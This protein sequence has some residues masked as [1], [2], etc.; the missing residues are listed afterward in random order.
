M[1][2]GAIALAVS[3]L[4]D[5]GGCRRSACAAGPR[6]HLSPLRAVLALLAIIAAVGLIG[7]MTSADA[8]VAHVFSTSFAVT[9]TPASIAVDQST[10]NVYVLNSAGNIQ[11]FSAAGA[12]V[13]FSSLGTNVLSTGCG[14]NCRQVAVDNSGGINQG[15]I[16]VSSSEAQLRVFLPSGRPGSSIANASRTS[17]V[18]PFCGVATD[19]SGVVYVVHSGSENGEVSYGNYVDT[20]K[21]GQIRPDPSPPQTWLVA[22][23]MGR[24]GNPQPCRVAV[25]ANFHMYVVP[26]SASSQTVTGQLLRFAINPFGVSEPAGIPIDTGSSYQAVNESN[27]DL[28]SDH[29]TSIRRFNAA[30]VLRE[31]FGTGQLEE[32]YGVAVN[33]TNGTVYATSKKAPS[34]V[35]IFNA[36]IT[37]DATTGLA[38]GGQ[39]T[40][41]IAGLVETADAG[42]VTGCQFEYGTSTAYG[43]TAACTPGAPFTE[44]THVT[45]NLTGLSKETT[46]HYRI[47][48]TNANGTTLGIDQ[49]FT[50]HNV[51]SVGTEPPTEVSQMSA[52]LRGGFVG[53]GEPM[54]YYFEWGSTVSYGNQ[55]AVP[56]GE[57][58]G[59][60]SGPTSV[61][62]AITGLSVRLP[63]STPYHY[64]L[65]AIN[66]S[67]TTYSPDRTFFAAPP[68]PPQIDGTSSSEVAPTSATVSATINPGNGPTVYYLEYGPDASYGSSTLAGSSI[69]SDNLEHAVSSIL[70]GLTPGTTYHYRVVASN[71]GGT[72][73]GADQSFNTPNAPI[74]SGSSASGIGQTAATLEAQVLPGFSSAT[75]HFEY[76][77]TS[78]YGSTTAESG[79][80]G[81]DNAAHL[82]QAS[83]GGLKPG[84]AY[85][86]R[87]VVTNQIGS[88]S[89]PDG[90]FTTS[91]VPAAKEAPREQPKPV[92]CKRG[93]VKK[94]GKCVRKPTQE[95]RR[96]KSRKDGH[97]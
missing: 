28:Y 13:N 47:T 25:D 97:R 37:P 38:A 9:G 32:S 31:T 90:T 26:S 79:S 88:T 29:V 74:V 91:T 81:S 59:S 33:G 43:S 5:T 92:R 58:L 21:P 34:S 30:G 49:T 64:R 11:K 61:S 80:V 14:A 93:F 6:A 89:G 66:G 39:T 68:L 35:K 83:I 22:G 87:V 62:A 4:G 57:S 72:A 71:F 7:P 12:P 1:T 40:A 54:S 17:F 75:Y 65:V 36:V 76:G 18:E 51:A 42:T 85:H 63:E 77:M 48:A 19:P 60:P 53:N 2:T 78:A 95:H 56:P 52:T 46:Y 24:V 44:T 50:T 96:H 82:A 15:V 16:Y 45:A 70:A 20:F 84:T 73:I 94:H 86:Y 55:T 3:K 23:T 8:E 69:G 41:T 27:N 10:G 67:G